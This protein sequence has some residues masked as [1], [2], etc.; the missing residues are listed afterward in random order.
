ML[1]FIA[2]FVDTLEYDYMFRKNEMFNFPRLINNSVTTKL[3][4]LL[5]SLSAIILS[6]T[7]NIFRFLFGFYSSMFF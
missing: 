7:I 3:R 1:L 2:I 6:K 5:L 4:F